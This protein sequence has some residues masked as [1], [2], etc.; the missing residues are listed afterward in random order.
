MVLPTTLIRSTRPIRWV[1][2]CG[3]LVAAVVF[4]LVNYT[5]TTAAKSLGRSPTHPHS[6]ATS[7]AR[8]ARPPL[9]A[10]NGESLRSTG[11]S[12]PTMSDGVLPGPTSVFSNRYAAISH[13]DASMLISLRRAAAEASSYGIAIDIDSGWRSRAY[14]ERLFEQAIAQYGSEQA[15]ARWVARPGTSIHEAGRAVDVVGAAAQAWLLRNGAGYG[16]CRMYRNEPW[17]VEWRPEAISNGCPRM[18][19]DPTDDPRLGS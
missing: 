9:G 7:T 16:L 15:A 2:L 1:I 18:Y 5:A 19:G 11:G 14:Q 13:L 12:G 8:D 10:P 4:G 3:V 6:T 17:H